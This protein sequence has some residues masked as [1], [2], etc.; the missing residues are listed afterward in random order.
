MFGDIPSKYQVY[1]FGDN[2]DSDTTV[3][4]P[5]EEQQPKEPITF[6]DAP[7]TTVTRTIW[8]TATRYITKLPMVTFNNDWNFRSGE[9][10]DFEELHGADMIR[11]RIPFHRQNDE[12]NY[13][14]P[15]Y[16]SES[17]DEPTPRPEC[18]IPLG[19]VRQQR[20][21]GPRG[22]KTDQQLPTQAG[23]V[24]DPRTIKR[25]PNGRRKR[26]TT[27]PDEEAS[28]QNATEMSVNYEPE[29]Q[30]PIWASYGSKCEEARKEARKNRLA[31]G[32]KYCYL[33]LF[34]QSTWEY[35]S[36]LLGPNPRATTVYQYLSEG[37]NL[38][39]RFVR[40]S[41]QGTNGHVETC[42]TE[43]REWLGTLRR[44]ALNNAITIGG[45]P[46]YLNDLDFDKSYKSS[47]TRK[48][49][50]KTSNLPQKHHQDGA[51]L[52]PTPRQSGTTIPNYEGRMQPYRKKHSYDHPA[53]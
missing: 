29:E 52:Q 46:Q 16:D 30:D 11:V 49:S 9:E 19:N 39:N 7:V 28:F 47:Y 45:Q 21:R 17:E 53:D 50:T 15:I 20:M 24:C 18:R 3:Q 13:D 22:P 48:D 34:A 14:P 10:Y 37:I 38:R 44:W 6:G 51:L 26:G 2:N 5:K 41:R 31:A 4:G 35:I 42:E 40:L 12:D 23:P 36:A 8:K 33:H 27:M 43:S 1:P 32:D 25:P